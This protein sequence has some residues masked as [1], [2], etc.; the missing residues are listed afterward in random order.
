MRVRRQSG[1]LLHHE[2][3][4]PLGLPGG[5]HCVAGP[6][7]HVDEFV[8]HRCRALREQAQRPLVV[9]CRL[10]RPA[11]PHRLVTRPDAGGQC[12]V[13]VAGEVGVPGQLGRGATGDA[14]P[15]GS[16]VPLVKAHPLGGQ[17]VVVRRLA[18]QRVPEGVPVPVGHHDVHL[19]RLAHAIVEVS[20]RHG[21]DGLEHVVPDQ[22]TACG[23]RLHHGASRRVEPVE[24]HQQHLGQVGRHPSPA[25]RGRDQLLDEEGVAL[26]PV[27]DRRQL[28]VIE[29]GRHQLADEGPHCLVGQP[30]ERDPVHQPG[31]LRH[32]AAERVAPVQVVGAVRRHQ[33]HRARERPCEQVAEE[34][35]GRSVRPVEILDDDEQRRLLGRRLEQPVDGSEELAA[36]GLL[37][38]GL[39]AERAAARLQP[40]EDRSFDD[41]L[42]HDRG[43]RGPEVLQ[44]LG[45][46]Q[47]RE[48][49]LAEVDAMPDHD[50]PAG[51]VGQVGELGEHPGLPNA[52][53]AR[54]E[55]GAAA[56]EVAGCGAAVAQG[57]AGHGNAEQR[58]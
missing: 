30:V 51:G 35:A 36:P 50:P 15:E 20:V 4:S 54:Q 21:S 22:P 49:A 19:D 58:S 10:V 28:G 1:E 34:V 39:R 32:L 31:P 40:G 52:C 11:D 37:T 57:V 42:R 29:P 25:T 12:G 23:R 8:V 2:L 47:I 5:V 45:E 38:F 16:D 53:I 3:D 9:M 41:D 18:E 27:D 33:A 17:Q 56:P 55:H 44:H 43:Q 26:R 6:D 14:V 7:H 13:P 24:A 46:G 48:R